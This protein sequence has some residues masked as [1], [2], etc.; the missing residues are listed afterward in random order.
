LAAGAHGYLGPHGFE[1]TLSDALSQIERDY[2]RHLQAVQVLNHITRWLDDQKQQ[3]DQDRTAAH[4][5]RTRAK[6]TRCRALLG[7]ALGNAV[8]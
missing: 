2:Q 4:D 5:R 7:D 3:S 8:P 1:R 6:Q